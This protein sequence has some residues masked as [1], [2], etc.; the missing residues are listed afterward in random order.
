MMTT[1]RRKAKKKIGI[2]NMFAKHCMHWNWN[3]T[4]RIT[5]K[6]RKRWKKRTHKHAKSEGAHDIWWR[7]FPHVYPSEKMWLTDWLSLSSTNVATFD[8]WT[9]VEDGTASKLY[10]YFNFRWLWLCLKISECLLPDSQSSAHFFYTGAYYFIL[11]RSYDKQRFHIYYLI[12]VASLRVCAYVCVVVFL[13]VCFLTY[14]HILI[15]IYGRQWFC[16]FR[17]LFKF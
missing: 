9:D 8:D 10:W 15:H 16:S 4:K 11:F 12:F 5:K 6:W 14:A 3:K 7:S 1:E 2:A 13:F 17:C